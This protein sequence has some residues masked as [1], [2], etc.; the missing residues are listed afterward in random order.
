M[1]ANSAGSW[2]PDLNKAR[3][4]FDQGS[5]SFLEADINAYM[6]PFIKGA[7]D[8][9]ARELREDASIRKNALAGQHKS[10]GAFGGGRASLMEEETNK[11]LTEGISDLYGRGYAQAFESGSDR[12]AADR[13]NYNQSGA[14]FL[15]TAGVQSGLITQDIDNLMRTGGIERSVQQNMADFD[16]AEFMREENWT[17]DNINTILTALQ[18]IKGSTTETRKSKSEQ[19]G[20]GWGKILGLAATAAGAYMTGGMSLAAQGAMQQGR[21]SGSGSGGGAGIGA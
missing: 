7:L 9:A 1:A 21:D 17:K 6:N 15:Q 8:P 10:M 4:F 2:Q 19:D 20:G 3:G 12:W 14:N 18:G 13:A 5:Q 16:F 11:T